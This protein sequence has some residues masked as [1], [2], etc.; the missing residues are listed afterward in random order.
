MGVGGSIVDVDFV[1]GGDIEVGTMDGE[2]GDWE[3]EKGEVKLR[4]GDVSGIGDGGESLERWN[5]RLGLKGE[6]ALESGAA[7]VGSRCRRRR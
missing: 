3:L 4:N 2:M 1:S 7:S 6:I 5:G